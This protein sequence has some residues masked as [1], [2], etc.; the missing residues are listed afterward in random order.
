MRAISPGQHVVWLY[1]PR[2]QRH[3]VYLVDAEIVQVSTLRTRI[4]IKTTS[5]QTCLRWVKSSNLRA[6]A[7]GEPPYFY[8]ESC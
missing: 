8:P 2:T 7:P 5:G 3:K 6:K 4:R 1:R